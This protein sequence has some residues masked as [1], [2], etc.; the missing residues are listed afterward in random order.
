MLQARCIIYWLTLNNLQTRREE[1]KND[2]IIGI[3][4]FISD[5][6]ERHQIQIL[7]EHEHSSIFKKCAIYRPDFTFTDQQK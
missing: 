5:T 6:T 4:F 1:V 3:N 2:E 7:P